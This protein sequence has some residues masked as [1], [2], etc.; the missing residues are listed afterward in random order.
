MPCRLVL[1][2]H[3]GPTVRADK[4]ISENFLKELATDFCKDLMKDSTNFL[5]TLRSLGESRE[6]TD[7]FIFSADVVA[8]YD[9]LQR[10]NVRSAL[11]MAMRE[12]RDWD[13]D[14]R[15]WIINCVDL[16]W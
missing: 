12:C 10:E 15:T 6:M 13:E 4:Y 1:G 3:L 8:L 2:L 9:N 7:G 16:S 11:D 14:K 5:Q